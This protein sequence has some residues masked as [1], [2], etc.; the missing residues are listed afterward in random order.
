MF[1]LK[2]RFNAEYDPPKSLCF[3]IKDCKID[4]NNNSIKDEGYKYDSNE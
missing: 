4:D 3:E 2:K 1:I